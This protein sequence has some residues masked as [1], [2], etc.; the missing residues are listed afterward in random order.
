MS[1]PEL[2]I[3]DGLDIMN[4]TP[5]VPGQTGGVL[6][7]NTNMKPES[8]PIVEVVWIDAEEHGYAGWNDLKEMMKKAKKPCPVM[9]SV[10]Y[11]VFRNDDHIALLS[12]IGPDECST[13]EKIPTGF[14]RSINVLRGVTASATPSPAT[15]S[16]KRSTA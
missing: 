2:Y 11:E 13:L 14:I 3:H 8:L 9:N 1:S 5:P 16:R 10:G 6:Y 7:I 4:P 15:K 12:T